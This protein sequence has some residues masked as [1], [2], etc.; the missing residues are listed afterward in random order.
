MSSGSLSHLYLADEPGRVARERID[1]LHPQ[2]V[3]GLAEQ[4][5]IGVVLTRSA[6]G[7][8]IADGGSG[9]RIV[10][11][12]GTSGGAGLD[13]LAAYGARAPGDVAGLDGKSH[14]GDL[15]LLGRLDASLDE[16]AAFEELVGSH[17]GLGGW[18]THAMVIHPS[19]WVLP[20]ELDGLAVHEAL[21]RR[22]EQVGLRPVVDAEPVGV[23]PPV[24][25][26]R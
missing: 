3:R 18:Q 17:G 12:G 9:W 5:H 23:R 20:V 26:P 16:V 21:M 1:E 11:S 25:G 7:D 14:V 24:R 4:A 6:E 2:L 15:V 13:P 10:T 22:Q 19:S 8:L